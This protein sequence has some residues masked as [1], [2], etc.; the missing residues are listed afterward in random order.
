MSEEREINE[1]QKKLK[2]DDK[3]YIFDNLPEEAKNIING[4]QTVDT[5]LRMYSDTI[6]L[7]NISKKTMV[8]NLKNILQTV[9]PIEN[10]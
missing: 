2:F 10:A 3:H 4:L 7:I 1:S 9:K 8:D 5:Q 6:K